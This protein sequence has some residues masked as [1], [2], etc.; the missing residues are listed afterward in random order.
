MRNSIC[1]MLT[2]LFCKG[3]D[4]RGFRLSGTWDLGREMRVCFFRCSSATGDRYSDLA[5]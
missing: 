2:E 1:C 3:H 4:N 5:S